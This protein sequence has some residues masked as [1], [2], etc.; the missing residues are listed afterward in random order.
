MIGQCQQSRKTG[1][2]ALLCDA[3]AGVPGG[4]CCHLLLPAPLLLCKVIK[5]SSPIRRCRAVWYLQLLLL[6]LLQQLL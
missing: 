3:R 5:Q 6:V 1:F 4:C 2:A